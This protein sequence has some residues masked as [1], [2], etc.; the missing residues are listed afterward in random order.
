[1]DVLHVSMFSQVG[2]QAL[3]GQQ[4]CLRKSVHTFIDFEQDGIVMYEGGQ[5]VF[6]HH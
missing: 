4:A 6:V 3:L 5:T 1:M 2:D